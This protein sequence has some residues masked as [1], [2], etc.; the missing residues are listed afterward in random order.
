M[1]TTLARRI[2]R[3]GIL[4]T[5]FKVSTEERLVKQPDGTTAVATVERKTPI[6]HY[7]PMTESAR[8]LQERYLR[9]EA[10]FAR[11]ARKANEKAAR[12][13]IAAKK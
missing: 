5:T 12:E 6:R 13:R 4:P 1:T 10:K 7:E 3:I 2:R 11:A 9:Q 8:E